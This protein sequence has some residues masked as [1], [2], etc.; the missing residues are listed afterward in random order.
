MLRHFNSGRFLCCDE[1][2]NLYLEKIQLDTN[3][4][5]LDPLILM[6]Q[7]IQLGQTRLLSNNSYKVI[8]LREQ[9]LMLSHSPE[10]LSWKSLESNVKTVELEKE[11]MFSPLD[12]N[13][14][15]ERRT[16][17]VTEARKLY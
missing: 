17:I 8:S 9:N 16:V 3:V 12:D 5:R 4:Q 10:L 13:Y 2:K 7:P 6:V 14:F 1:K 11:I 15:D